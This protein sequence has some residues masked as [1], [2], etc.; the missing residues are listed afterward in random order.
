MYLRNEGG[1]AT[2]TII[3]EGKKRQHEVTVRGGATSLESSACGVER[4]SKDKK[5]YRDGE[6]GVTVI[7]NCPNRKGTSGK[8]QQVCGR[9]NEGFWYQFCGWGAQ[10]T[11]MRLKEGGPWIQRKLERSV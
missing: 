10:N 1:K 4:E 8:Y 6:G 2:P 11:Q 9:R 7:A 5:R 3:F